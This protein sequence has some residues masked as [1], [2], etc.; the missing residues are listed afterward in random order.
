MTHP[1][2]YYSPTLTHPPTYYSPTLTHPPNYPYTYHYNYPYPYPNYTY[3][4]TYPTTPTP[5]GP[6]VWQPVG[7]NEGLMPGSYYWQTTELSERLMT[8]GY[9]QAPEPNK[10]PMPKMNADYGLIKDGQAMGYGGPLVQQTSP[11]GQTGPS[12][13][14]RFEPVEQLSADFAGGLEKFPVP[15]FGPEHERERV[16]SHYWSLHW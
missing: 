4:Y 15:V 10:S 13:A 9:W 3:T 6:T 16:S 5:E 8:K 2:T 12:G 14:H 1:P 7:L 11:F